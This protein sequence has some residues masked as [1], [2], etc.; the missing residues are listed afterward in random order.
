M[1][2]QIRV[3]QIRL[4]GSGGEQMGLFA[5]DGAIK[6]AFDEGL[7]LVEIDPNANPPV[8]KIM[9]YG[10]YK[11]QLQKRQHE[12]KKKQIVVHVKEIKIRPNIDEHDIEFKLNHVRRFLED[13]DKAKITLQFRGREMMHAD[14]GKEL[15]DKFIKGTEGL[16]EVETPPKMEGRNLSMVLTP[17]SKKAK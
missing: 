14:R 7:D 13:K 16:G 4:I 12:S 10:K 6:I 8:C 15:M 9:D 2:R 11:Y 1:N 17:L 5:T 3:P